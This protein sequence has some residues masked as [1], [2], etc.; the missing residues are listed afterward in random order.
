MIRVKYITLDDN[1][2][3]AYFPETKRF[4][5]VDDEMKELIGDIS[6]ESK[7]AVMEK[8]SLEDAG[9][10]EYLSCMVRPVKKRSSQKTDKKVLRRLVIHLA[11]D[12]NLRCVYCYANGGVY[13]SEQGMISREMLDRIMEVFYGEFDSIEMFQLFGGEP[14]LDLDLLEYACKRIRELEKEH[15]GKCTVGLVTNGTLIN[16]RFID[17][18]KTYNVA[19]TIS[20]DG[21]P[22][23]NDRLRP[24]P[25]G[26]GSSS[27]I[28]ENMKKYRDAVGAFGIEVT[29]S[30]IHA[31]AGVSVMEIYDHLHEMFPEAGIHIAPAGGTDACSFALLDTEAFPRGMKEYA[32][33]LINDPENPCR[34]YMSAESTIDLLEDKEAEPMSMFCGAGNSTLSVNTKGD[35]YPCFM[36]TD[37]DELH[38]GNVMEDNVF[39]SEHF[40]DNL[41]R[42][43]AFSQK[44]GH[45]E[46]RDC[47]ID[48][49]CGP[50]LGQLLLNTGEVF[51]LSP[52]DCERYRRTIEEGIKGLAILSETME[53]MEAKAEE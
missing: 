31:D 6:Q 45:E 8:W 2:E 24:F 26:S 52:R 14:L 30:Q 21:T 17:I 4:F 36:L 9:Y 38:L 37:V 18:V 34:A 40:K 28:L 49:V 11:N 43:L 51:K 39:Q 47:F 16:D 50:C 32:R 44:K 53:A 15:N 3:L 29:Y 20:Y 12:C 33:R 13:R 10:E 42:L 35:I 22:E 48:T 46:C 27:L 19:V 5:F 41:Y 25:D 23:I 7:P 1:R